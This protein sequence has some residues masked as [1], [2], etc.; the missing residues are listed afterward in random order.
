LPL[1][2]SPTLA[3]TTTGNDRS[4]RSCSPSFERE[5]FVKPTIRDV[6][7]VLFVLA[8]TGASMHVVRGQNSDGGSA[9]EVKLEKMKF[10]EL[11]KVVANKNVKFTIV[12]AWAT[13]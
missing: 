6:R 1:D 5:T 9:K 11:R 2:S 3:L 8:L 13:W 10:D 7:A 4:G 12:D